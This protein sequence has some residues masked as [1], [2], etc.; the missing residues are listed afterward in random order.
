MLYIYLTLASWCVGWCLSIYFRKKELKNKV[1]LMPK[2]LVTQL[3]LFII[4]ALIFREYFST[5]FID[6]WFLKLGWF[7]IYFIF[8]SISFYAVQVL[9]EFQTW[10]SLFATDDEMRAYIEKLESDKH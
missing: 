5:V 10:N 8:S 9:Y 2:Q 4:F 1:I 3:A 7:L 6:L